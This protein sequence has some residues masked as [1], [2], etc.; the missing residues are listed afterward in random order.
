M[1]SWHPCSG[2][3]LEMADRTNEQ[4]HEPTRCVPACD[5]MMFLLFEKR[6]K[7][8]SVEKCVLCCPYDFENTVLQKEMDPK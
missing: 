5:V 4:P 1:L 8:V 2:R 6:G 3:H 7:C